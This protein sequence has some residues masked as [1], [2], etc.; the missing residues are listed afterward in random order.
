MIL[1]RSKDAVDGPNCEE[2]L[3]VIQ[4]MFGENS[5]A[6]STL[7]QLLH[8]P[9]CGYDAPAPITPSFLRLD[10][11]WTRCVPIPLSK[12]SARKSSTEDTRHES[13]R[14]RKEER[15]FLLPAKHANV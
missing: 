9:Y 2:N 14:I 1:P 7:T 8:T 5:R 4:T 13:S 15:A 11:I 12:N 10:P 6:I 3:A